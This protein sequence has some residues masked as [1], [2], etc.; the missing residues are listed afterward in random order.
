MSSAGAMLAQV[1]VVEGQEVSCLAWSAEKF[2]LGEQAAAA[3]A[4]SNNNTTAGSANHRANTGDLLTH[5]FL[6]LKYTSEMDRTGPYKISLKHRGFILT[7]YMMIDQ[8][9]SYLHNGRNYSFCNA[10]IN[11]CHDCSPCKRH[12][13][14]SMIILFA[15]IHIFCL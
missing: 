7:R 4:A 9:V 2:F 11:F 15:Q 8:M 5:I 1:T 12:S 10:V 13:T 14:L 3:A 6:L